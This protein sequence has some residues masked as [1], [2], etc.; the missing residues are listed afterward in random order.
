LD[1]KALVQERCTQ[2]HDLQR[3]EAA[4]KTGDEWKANVE[5]M[6]SLGAKLDEA[7]QEAA[8]DYLTEAYPK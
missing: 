1:G 3:V 7:E 8:I 5:R 2:C 4:K 6:V